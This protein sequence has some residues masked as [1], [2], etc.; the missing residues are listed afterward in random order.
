MQ[1]L[2]RVQTTV[3]S[4]LLEAIQEAGYDGR[5]I[6]ATANIEAEDLTGRDRTITV[7][8]FCDFWRAAMEITGERN[9]GLK[10]GTRF[11]VREVGLA[12][13]IFVNSET[14]GSALERL[15]RYIGLYR[16]NVRFGLI[17][18]ATTARFEMDTESGG[19]PASGQYAELVAA[20]VVGLIRIA[21]GTHWSPRRMDFM[22][23]APPDSS[24]HLEFFRCPL[25]FGRRR[26]QIVMPVSDLERKTPNADPRLLA[27]LVA[28]VE[29]DLQAARGA[30]GDLPA[31]ESFIL[32]HLEETPQSIEDAAKYMH[33]SV[34]TLQRRLR[35]DGHTFREI[36]DHVRRRRAL[37]LVAN[38]DLRLTDVAFLSG[39]SDVSS[40]QHAFKRW[41]GRSPGN[42]RRETAARSA[43]R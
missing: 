18:S 41:T 33:M 29:Q 11:D 15:A 1:L 39:F 25:R 8:Q 14:L 23:A 16:R 40:F 6:L 42:Y 13:Y 21:I 37:D 17:V 4:C 20:S 12:G 3:V 30:S 27:L 43:A 36:C 34:R 24:P 35:E 9:L 28:E 22:H 32:Q 7:Q 5:A 26:T 2:S 38:Q 19:E 10:L 31:I